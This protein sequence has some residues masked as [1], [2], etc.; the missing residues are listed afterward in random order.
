MARTL[1]VI[2]LLAWAAFAPAASAAGLPAVQRSLD[3][4]M[5]RS[6]PAAGAY[7]V[8]LDSGAV[9]YARNADVPRVPASVQKLYTTST[10][11]LRLGA[12]GRLSTT[13]EAAQAPDASGVLDGNLYLRG[14]GDPTF[15]TREAR[16]LAA[17]L[18]LQGLT[19]VTG[20]VVGDESAFDS[21]RG[22]PASGYATSMWV[23]PL[24]ALSFNRGLT[25][26][27][28]PTFQVNPPRS[29]ARAFDRAL[30]RRSIAVAHAARAGVA[31]AG[32]LTLATQ[33]SATITDL[34]DRT[35]RPSDNFMAETLLKALGA[36]FGGAGSTAAG[37]R[38]VRSTVARFG[39]RPD[40][41]D[42][43]GLSRGDRTSPRDVV[44]LLE[45]MASTGD[46]G[47]FQ[48]SLPVAGISGTLWDRMRQSP[49]RGRCRAKTGSL[50][51]ASALAGYCDSRAG[52]RV[53]FAFLMNGVAPYWVRPRQ[54]AMTSVLARYSP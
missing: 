45:G 5:S 30:E 6:G 27:R 21:L 2:A 4:Q 24:S 48:D 37:A 29:A 7:V 40:V 8:D 52:A 54:D 49:A 44:R 13:A 43:S 31:P 26:H 14:G 32:V 28:R 46:A 42:G 50:S 11:L 17:T 18:E 35:N 12:G 20:R 38:V 33:A 22:G 34:I 10:A 39:A 1:C 19:E 25:G 9:L 16:R 41:V 36:R 53:A 23:G 3:R 51:T 15:G 47:A